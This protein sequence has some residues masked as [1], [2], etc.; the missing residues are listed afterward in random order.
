MYKIDTADRYQIC[1]VHAINGPNGRAVRNLYDMTCVYCK[2]CAYS[3]VSWA[4]AIG[5]EYGN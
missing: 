1:T 3:T 4:L 5:N 2:R